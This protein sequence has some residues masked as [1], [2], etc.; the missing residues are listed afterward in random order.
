MVVVVVGLDVR[1]TLV[2]GGRS[3]WL[4]EIDGW[5]GVA[6]GAQW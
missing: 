2:V 6:S 3:W 1:W 4:V 5:L